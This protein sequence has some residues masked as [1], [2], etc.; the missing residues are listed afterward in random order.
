M[1]CF[2]LCW[3]SK[4]TGT[5]LWWEV[6]NNTWKRPFGRPRTVRDPGESILKLDWGWLC[7]LEKPEEV[8]WEEVS[9]LTG[10]LSF[11]CIVHITSCE[12]NTTKAEKG[13]I[14]FNSPESSQILDS[15]AKSSR[16]PSIITRKT[17]YYFCSQHKKIFALP[18]DPAHYPKIK[19]SSLVTVLTL[20]KRTSGEA[21]V[22]S[23]R[24]QLSLKK[25]LR[26]T[27]EDEL[28]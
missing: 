19:S 13:M 10:W 21:R 6:P 18:C 3:L 2:W 26:G 9:A 25:Q 11:F 28:Q 24:I 23:N 27:R 4:L 22:Q 16:T 17:D 15:G 7:V 12:W 5:P 8:V 20:W 1:W 14:F